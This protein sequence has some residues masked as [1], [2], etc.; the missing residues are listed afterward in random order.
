M[1]YYIRL[2]K[3]PRI[4]TGR[5]R[6]ASVK[7]VITITTDLGDSFF[8][9][10]IELVSSLVDSHYKVE[11]LGSTNS[12]W[13]NGMRS[14]DAAI[15]IVNH[16]EINWPIRLYIHAGGVKQI[17]LLSQDDIPAIVPVSSDDINLG[18]DREVRRRV[19]RLFN[20]NGPNLSI[21]EDTG[22]SIARHV[23]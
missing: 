6:K 13:R 8:P 18:I 19:E 2:L 15:E 23:W 20:T 17:V 11:G 21:W 12:Q 1:V 9:E 14:V 10:D 4:V 22:E 16:P 3:P 7:V 5:K